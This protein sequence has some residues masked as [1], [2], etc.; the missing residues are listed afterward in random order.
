[1]DGELV[2][3]AAMSPQHPFIYL[4]QFYTDDDYDEDNDDDE[5]RDDDD[6]DNDE[7]RDDDDNEDHDVKDDD[8]WELKISL[9]LMFIIF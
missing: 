4:R 1:M 7:G 8:E 2:L 6:D 3:L 5:G 9:F